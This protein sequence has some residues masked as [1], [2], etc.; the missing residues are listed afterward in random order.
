[1][2]RKIKVK[3]LKKVAIKITDGTKVV[4]GYISKVRSEGEMDIP[5]E[6][7]QEKAKEIWKDTKGI[8]KTYLKLGIV[9]SI[10]VLESLVKKI[11]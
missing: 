7:V 9:K 6:Q 10:G 4:T 11:S 5:I 2:S 8:S 1:M 3:G